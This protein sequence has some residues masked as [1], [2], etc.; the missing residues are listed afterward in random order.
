MPTA[1]G[2]CRGRGVRGVMETAAG[3]PQLET[4]PPNVIGDLLYD[5]FEVGSDGVGPHHLVVLMLHDM[6]V[7][8]EASGHVELRLDAGDLARIDGDGVLEATFPG[9]GRH[10]LAERR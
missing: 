1:V 2:A 7:P 5:R 4:E 10:V 3:R 9:L 6:A 8:D